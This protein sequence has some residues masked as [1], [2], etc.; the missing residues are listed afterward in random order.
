MRGAAE[1]GS[2]GVGSATQSTINV[3]TLGIDFFD[4][5]TKSLVWR[6]QGTKTIDPSGNAQKN[7]ERL[8]KSIAKILKNFPPGKK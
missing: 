5:A 1:R 7:M 6:G 3:G 4:P 2:G 8:Q